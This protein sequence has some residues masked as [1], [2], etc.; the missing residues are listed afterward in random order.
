[1]RRTKR[2]IQQISNL[3]GACAVI[4]AASVGF[5]VR[6]QEQPSATSTPDIQ[7]DD[8]APLSA[9]ERMER[10]RAGG[11]LGTPATTPTPTTP[12]PAPT[13]TPAPAPQATEPAPTP[14]P[15]PKAEMPAP[16]PTPAPAAPE[17]APPAEPQ[18]VASQPIVKEDTPDDVVA[19]P[20]I[21]V[22]SG[23]Y[24][25][26]TGHLSN[27]TRHYSAD[28]KNAKASIFDGKHMEGISNP[29]ADLNINVTVRASTEALYDDNVFLRPS[30]EISSWVF[31]QTLGINVAL[32]DYESREGNYLAL[33]Y[34]PAYVYY[35]ADELSDDDNFAQSV[36]LEGQV[37]TGRLKVGASAGYSVR[38]G[39]SADLG[40][41]EVNDR[42][43]LS[44]FQAGVNAQYDVSDRT[45]IILSGDY[46]DRDYDR[47]ID[48]QTWSARAGFMTS[49]SP[50][51]QMGLTGAYG[52]VDADERG[53]EDFQQALLVLNYQATSRISLV[54]NA[55]VDFRQPSRGDDYENFVFGLSGQWNV[56][57]G[58]TI[59]L[60]G[61]RNVEPSAILPGQNLI[62]TGVT[63]GV[64]QR[65]FERFTLGVKGGY[66]K[67][68]YEDAGATVELDR[69]YDY[70]FV[71]PSLTYTGRWVDVE[72][73]YLFRSLESD[74]S[75]IGFDNNQ[76][77]IRVGVTF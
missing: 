8:E 4:V 32:G 45:A 33:D 3:A 63:A 46:L 7:N 57:D 48:S 76:V 69:D 17:E 21:R 39:S 37:V 35:E 31:I 1:M 44:S 34:S 27:V 58:T 40:A 16:A 12:A 30:G 70:Y 42:V 55:G 74:N 20:S 53:K 6:A 41:V 56:T 51:V 10:R 68:T 67:V 77:G 65:L 22:P 73:Y 54:A 9:R 75:L 43:D 24:G 2:P 11:A 29:V 36:T 62:L 5:P 13:P 19:S 52:Q 66:D 59:A 25:K 47:F 28:S 50:K 23:R 26:S 64:T 38:E 72:L 71:R 60:E 49:I 15:A 61:H 14:P 18:P